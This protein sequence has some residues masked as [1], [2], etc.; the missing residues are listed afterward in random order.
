MATVTEL[1]TE[2]RNDRLCS[3]SKASIIINQKYPHSVKLFVDVRDILKP[4]FTCFFENPRSLKRKTL[5]VCD[6]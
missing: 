2:T 3:P 1:I 6:R 4:D 5:R